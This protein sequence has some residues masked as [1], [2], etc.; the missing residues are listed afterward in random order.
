MTAATGGDGDTVT[1]TPPSGLADNDIL[2][3]VIYC[4]SAAQAI[5]PPSGFA[6]FQRIASASFAAEVFWKRAASESG[7]Y[8]W[9][10]TGNAWGDGSLFAVSGCITTETPIGAVGADNNGTDITAEATG[11][12]TTTANS[13]LCYVAVNFDSLNM[14]TGPTGMTERFDNDN[15]YLATLDVATAS[16]TGD[17]TGTWESAME[18]VALLFELKSEAAAG[19]A[20]A[21]VRVRRMTMLGVG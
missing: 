19:G 7:N 13:L 6:S 10:E 16:A 11:I 8:V 15:E 2:V 9:T 14:N 20:S 1:L 12:T 5:S 18:W 21:P 17:K 4:E 3:G